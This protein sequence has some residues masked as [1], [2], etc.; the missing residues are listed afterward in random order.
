MTNGIEHASFFVRSKVPEIG[1]TSE[2]K[3]RDGA[4]H[5]PLTHVPVSSLRA[6]TVSSVLLP[7]GF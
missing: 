4:A 6:V 1:F 2:Q 3:E 7:G 5:P